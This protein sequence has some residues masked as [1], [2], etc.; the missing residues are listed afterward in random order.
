MLVSF[1]HYDPP[2]V[3]IGLRSRECMVVMNT[4]IEK[5]TNDDG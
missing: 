4:D 3:A 5:G 1:I 2:G